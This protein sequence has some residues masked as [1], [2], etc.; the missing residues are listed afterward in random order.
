[1]ES[2]TFSSVHTS[3][4]YITYTSNHTFW[5]IFHKLNNIHVQTIWDFKN[6]TIASSNLENY[7]LMIKLKIME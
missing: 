7:V 5:S 1:M 4:S 6:K 3:S 2:P